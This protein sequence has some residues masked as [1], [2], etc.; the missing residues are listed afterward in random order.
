MCYDDEIEHQAEGNNKSSSSSSFPYRHRYNFII[1][2]YDVW[3]WICGKLT[4]R[5]IYDDIVC[6]TY[7]FKVKDL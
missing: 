3:I 2:M 1:I 6:H 7:I 4:Q 5:E